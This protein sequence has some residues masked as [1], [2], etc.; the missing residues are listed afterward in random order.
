MP[1]SI[2]EKSRIELEVLN[3]EAFVLPFCRGH[4]DKAAFAAAANDNTWDGWEE[5]SC[6]YEPMHVLH[7]LARWEWHTW[8]GERIHVLVAVGE[9]SRGVFPITI[10]DPHGESGFK[11]VADG[12]VAALST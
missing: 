10:A 1:A 5:C 2:E 3:Y 4:V 9:R 6:D 7:A 8:D 12:D 11:E